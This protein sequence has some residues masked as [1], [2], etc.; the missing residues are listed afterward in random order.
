MFSFPPDST[1][2]FP[3]PLLGGVIKSSFLKCL[4]SNGQ[5]FLSGDSFSGNLLL[6]QMEIP[7]I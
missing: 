1:S 2:T 5:T 7:G 4:V 3:S 6:L